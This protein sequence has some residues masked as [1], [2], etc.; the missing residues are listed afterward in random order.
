MFDEDGQN[1][2]TIDEAEEEASSTYLTLDLGGQILGISVQNVREILDPQRITRLPNAPT[3]V[4]GV[5]DV[6]G[7]S[8]PI[9]DIKSKLGIC[10][11]EAGDDAR[12]VVLELKIDGEARTLGIEADCVRKVE[13]IPRAEIEPVPVHVSSNW[14]SQLIDGLYR[15]DGDLVVLIDIDRLLGGGETELDLS[16]GAGFF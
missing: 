5:A 15:R 13:Q 11:G 6:R 16:A 14:D 2:E 1:P 10:G 12:I 9:I 7:L 8:V 3:D 4:F